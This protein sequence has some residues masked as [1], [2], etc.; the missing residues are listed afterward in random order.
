MRASF[1]FIHSRATP[2]IASHYLLLTRAILK[3]RGKHICLQR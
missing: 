2:G 1:Y 3:M